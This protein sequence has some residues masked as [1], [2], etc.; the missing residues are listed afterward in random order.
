MPSIDIHPYREML[1]RFLKQK[2]EEDLLQELDSQITA[3]L[4]VEDPSS[5]PD[6]RYLL[7]EKVISAEAFV[8]TTSSFGSCRFRN[9]AGSDIIATLFGFYI[10]STAIVRLSAH[11]SVADLGNLGTLQ[12]GVVT[13]DSRWPISPSVLVVSRDQTLAPVGTRFSYAPCETD[14]VVPWPIAPV[15]LA[16]GSS[17]DFGNVAL[18]SSDY[19][20]LVNWTERRASTFE[21]S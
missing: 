8:N 6:W 12:T 21:L 4:T 2:G 16:P 13:R 1:R 10:T 7:G 17:I 19:S 14:K 3:V 15:V 5:R 18:S 9:P 20:V 11:M